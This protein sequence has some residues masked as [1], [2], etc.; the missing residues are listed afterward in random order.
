V[1]S[2]FYI[3]SSEAKNF[4]NGKIKNQQGRKERN[5]FRHAQKNRRRKHFVETGE[6]VDDNFFKS[7]KIGKTNISG[8]LIIYFYY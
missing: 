5:H 1:A 3:K 2:P 8:I 6:C 4:K 7:K